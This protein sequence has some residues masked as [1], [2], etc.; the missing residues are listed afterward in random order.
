MFFY[1]VSSTYAE[2]FSLLR[3]CSGLLSNS[4]E[5]PHRPTCK[6]SQL[7]MPTRLLADT[8]RP[9]HGIPIPHDNRMPNRPRYLIL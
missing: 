5:L 4:P 9:Y 1:V 8:D 3:I 2:I 6:E 7:N